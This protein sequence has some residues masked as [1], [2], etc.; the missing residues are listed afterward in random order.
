MRPV[1]CDAGRNWRWTL[2]R[3]GVCV[4]WQTSVGEDRLRR[5]AKQIKLRR[6]TKL[7][8]VTV[9]GI[10]RYCKLRLVNTARRSYRLS[11]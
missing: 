5:L 2:R 1:K 11:P 9:T 3:F 6:W 4:R 10:A 7:S 8:D